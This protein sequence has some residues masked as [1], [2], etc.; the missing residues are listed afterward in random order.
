VAVKVRVMGGGGGGGGQ[1]PTLIRKCITEQHARN[2]R[3]NNEVVYFTRLVTD[4]VRLSK[5]GCAD[6]G[7]GAP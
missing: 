3:L 5:L 2:I 4:I 1:W 6:E 7:R